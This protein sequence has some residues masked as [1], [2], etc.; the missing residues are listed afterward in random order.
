MHAVVQH[1]QHLKQRDP[2]L[3]MLVTALVHAGEAVAARA[4]HLALVPA[5]RSS[6]QSPELPALADE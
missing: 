2:Q 3:S 5:A 6:A 1:L 4:R